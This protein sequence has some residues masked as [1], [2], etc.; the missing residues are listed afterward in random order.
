MSI[1][2]KTQESPFSKIFAGL[3]IPL[4][5]L[6]AVMVYMFLFGD[7]SNFEGQNLQSSGMVDRFLGQDWNNAHPH[8]YF[9]I[10]YRG[11]FVVPV[12][13]ALF[14]IVVA[15]TLERLMTISAAKGKGDLSAL[16]KNV[17]THLANENI[18]AAIGECD[19]NKG[20]VGNVIRAGLIKY[21]QMANEPGMAKDQKVLAIQKEIEEATALE[22]PIME[23]NLVILA[24]ITSVGTLL[25][26]F[27]TVIGM[28][29]AFKALANAG[30]PD[31]V[32]LANGISEALINTAL[33]IIT[34]AIAIIMYNIFTSQIDSMTYKIDEAGLSIAQTFASKH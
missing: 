12:L 9:G 4:A 22:L 13:M 28:I 26:L 16:V 27:G 18:D 3:L 11:G 2:K 32:A 1:T 6:V 23:R 30:S 24:T 10:I 21:K 19:K 25:A 8:N 29:K 7:S 33:G 5:Y 17:Q 34:S 31:A 20:S 15:I 14:I